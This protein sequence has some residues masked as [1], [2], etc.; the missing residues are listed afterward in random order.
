[1]NYDPKNLTK[2]GHRVMK[3]IV[4]AV[5]SGRSYILIV[6]SRLSNSVMISNCKRKLNFNHKT[7]DWI[8]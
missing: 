3:E 7:I 6:S 1:M 5:Y 8:S 2:S 4:S